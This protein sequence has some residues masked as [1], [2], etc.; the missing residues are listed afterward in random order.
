MRFR[1]RIPSIPWV[2]AVAVGTTA[3][4]TAAVLSP[5]HADP[6]RPTG[7]QV[8]PYHGYHLTVPSDWQVVDLAAHPTT[9]VRFD[10]HTLYLGTPGD[11][12]DCPAGLSGRTEA[13]LVEPTV[14]PT[15]A[16][17]SV[18]SAADHQ[19][20]TAVP[21]VRVTAAY[22]TDRASILRVLADS[23]LP[24]AAPRATSSAGPQLSATL[25]ASVTNYRGKGFDACSAPSAASMS[26]WK[27]NSPYGAVNVYMGGPSRPC[28]QPNLS[29]SWVQQQA[30]AGWHIMPIYD[31]PQAPALSSP[32]S[33]GTSAADS[34]ISEALALGFSPGSV[35]YDDME[36][37]PSSYTGAVLSYVSAWTA[38]L[39]A[40]GWIAGMYGSASSLIED[41]AAKAGSPYDEPDV[42]WTGHWN[43][44]ADTEESAIPTGY[45]TAHQRVHQY[46]G[47]HNETYGG[48]TISIDGDYLDVGAAA[49]M[50]G[51]SAVGDQTGDGVPDIVAVDRSTGDLYRYS[52]PDYGGGTRVQI[53]N[54]WNVYQ[55]LVGVG[56]LNGDGHADLLAQTAS[57]DL[58]RYWGPGFT[59]SSKVQV[60][61]GWNT[62]AG[63]IPVGDLTGDGVPDVIA[64]ERSTGKL[65]RYAG[66]DFS[67]TTRVQIGVDWDI[68][69]T[70][71]SVGDQTG[72][73]IA[74]IVATGADGKLYRYSGPGY[75]GGSKVQV[76]TGWDT[77]SRLVGP[78]NLAGTGTPDLLT[79]EISSANLYRYLGPDFSGTTREQIGTRW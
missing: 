75:A 23:G 59:G 52:G 13:L 74:D 1:Y 2:P 40:R 47:T 32:A 29:A 39:H 78:G 20:T 19:I 48:V 8:V 72:D 56:D 42:L 33:Q 26:A 55:S 64:I 79:V 28:A 24:T 53:G 63:I 69:H 57:G 5:A 17:G 58:Y 43:G 16:S 65:F 34:A 7:S 27:S 10:H 68:Y 18:E 51:I 76:G 61:N 77:M 37:Y 50:N 73:G 67:G 70:L 46:S 11:V 31:G 4:L 21:G 3:L 30:A 36:Q 45:W 22:G 15:S 14:A 6:V 66:P 9:C 35:L 49:A 44:V 12:Q 25:P 41:L 38:E 54:G 71:A 62:M 60:G